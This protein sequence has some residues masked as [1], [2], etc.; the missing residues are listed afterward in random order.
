MRNYTNSVKGVDEGPLFP[1]FTTEAWKKSREYITAISAPSKYGRLTP[2]EQ[3]VFTQFGP[4]VLFILKDSLKEWADDMWEN[5]R[6]VPALDH[7]SPRVQYKLIE[8][9]LIYF[10]ELYEQAF[11]LM[12][13]NEKTITDGKVSLKSTGAG[14]KF[15]FN[16]MLLD[17][18]CHILSKHERERERKLRNARIGFEEVDVAELPDHSK[19][20]PVCLDPIGAENLEGV[21]ESAIKLVICCGQILGQLCLKKWLNEVNSHNQFIN[22]CPMCRSEF[23]HAFIGKLFPGEEALTREAVRVMRRRE[24]EGASAPEPII[25][26]MA[27]PIPGGVQDRAHFVRSFH[28]LAQAVQR[29]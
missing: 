24:R 10:Q 27:P 25:D 18:I 26:T 8:Q 28:S 3:E 16:L 22:S 15:V 2:V 14:V 21:T 23:S 29:P 4:V 12:G 6:K 1:G 17:R 19:D 13:D 7:I 9:Y 20:C 11:G 5:V